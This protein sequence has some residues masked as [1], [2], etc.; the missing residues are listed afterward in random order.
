MAK[1]ALAALVAATRSPLGYTYATIADAKS[2]VASG[3]AEQN[4]GAANPSNPKEFATRA[5]V[6]GLAKQDAIDAKAAAS[7]TPTF[8]FTLGTPLE[9]RKSTRGGG[10]KH[11]YPFADFP[12]PEMIDGKTV[13][14]RIFVP[15]TEAMP[16]PA[17]SL[18]STV[19]QASRDYARVVGEKPGKDR[20][21]KDIMRKTYEFDRKF[22]I[23]PGEATDSAGN[24]VKGA[25]IER[26]K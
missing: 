25:Y 20:T 3:D 15:A 26:V 12:A 11:K 8:T 13:P 1:L 16:N 5:S 10:R 18:S 6:A 22:A 24:V 21:G 7:A 17:K 9:D 19:S 2:L 14:H 4:S 23:L